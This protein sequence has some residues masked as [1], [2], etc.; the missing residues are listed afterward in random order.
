MKTYMRSF[1]C[2]VC[3]LSTFNMMLSQEAQFTK[4]LTPPSRV[5]ASLAYAGAVLD[6][7]GQPMTGVLGVT[8]SLYADEQG[9]AALWTENQNVQL[10]EQGRYSVAL[11]AIRGNLPDVFKSGEP[12]WLGAQ[13]QIMGA[14]EQPRVQLGS[15]P[16]A[17]KAGDAD[18]LGGKPLS[19]FV[20]APTDSDGQ[21]PKSQEPNISFSA[22]TGGTGTTNAL[23]KW[24]DSTGTL[25]DT[26][27]FEV[28]EFVGVGTNNPLSALH[29][30]NSHN[31]NLTLES[32]YATGPQIRFKNGGLGAPDWILGVPGSIDAN[33][34]FIYDLASFKQPF[35]IAKGA[36]DNSFSIN[37]SGNVGIGKANPTTKLDVAGT[38]K[39]TAFVGDG[40]Q[41]TNLPGGG[42]PA[43]D[44]NCSSPCI[45]TSEIL[46]SA[47]TST[48]IADG[49]IVDADVSSAAAIAPTKIAG[50]AAILG[51]N[52][53][54]ATQTI[55]TGNLNL[56][57]TSGPSTGVLTLGGNRF[58]HSYGVAN[59]FVGTNAGNFV[60]SGVQ[61]TGTGY[62]A[63]F[64]NGS[65]VNNTA[66]GYQALF[67][68][69]GGG[70]NTA[71][72]TVALYNNTGSSN[73][74]S[75]MA[76]LYSNTTGG[77]NTA[78]GMNSLFFNTTG[79]QNTATGSLALQSN[80]TGSYNTA[81]GYEAL[82]DNKTGS[83]NTATGY[84][85]MYTSAG[86][87]GA[88]PEY[89]VAMGANAL[90]DNLSDSNVAIGADALS[91]RG[92]GNNTA[93]GASAM[94]SGAGPNNTAVGFGAMPN[95]G[96]S[97]NSAFG[98][99][100]LTGYGGIENTAVGA[101]TLAANAGNYNVAT[102]S[103]ALLTNTTGSFNA[104][105][106]NQ[107]LRTNTTGTFNT[108]IGYL[109]D[110]SSGALTNATAIGANAVVNASN[111]IRLGDSAVTVIEGQVAY[112]FTSD[113][114]KKE[115]FQPVD[116]GDVLK[117]LATLDIPSW[118]YIGQDGKE[119]RHYGPMAQDFYAA[120][121]NDG[122]GTIGTPT[123]INSGDQAGILMLAVKALEAE[124]T[125]LRKDLQELRSALDELKAGLAK[126]DR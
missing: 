13:P 91:S 111:K 79:L 22:N 94:L 110:V 101:N 63:L 20:L 80:T 126:G 59:T 87:V 90:Y 47:V 78:T 107:A 21:K 15:M 109:A 26:G 1:L 14:A 119:F 10:D 11:G 81:S 92:S 3:L 72:G 43:G 48:L 16:Y 61:N 4:P 75:G 35:T 95:G 58:L 49:T 106:G 57:A 76:S 102:G 40:S 17:L 118:N 105:T 7:A 56:P 39:A 122:L 27:V 67:S 85:A 97:N 77:D 24:L 6:G 12:R 62:Q 50:T 32:A 52:T 5:P 84:R 19:A 70:N 45:S 125:S 29:V 60:T 93:V 98:A 96:A 42:G 65:G 113:K 69:S 37:S 121:G 108:A 18:T 100:A 71:S 86:P 103:Q 44:V 82:F 30:Q 116:A 123:A 31:A 55:S 41:L 8:F 88:V 73:T 66:S 53:F 23:M 2:V 33:S 83:Y 68:N 25:G 114:T 115:N 117:K 54:T 120:F 38:V 124:N 9:G 99:H 64:N 28:G 34:F 112:T 74:A 46:N 51:A 104:A 89:N 36:S